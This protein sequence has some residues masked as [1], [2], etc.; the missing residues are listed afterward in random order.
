MTPD[1]WH[2]VSRIF[3]ATL[4]LAAPEREGYLRAACA[5]DEALRREVASLLAQ[6][7]ADGFLAVPPE[8]PRLTGHRLGPYTL[9]DL[10]GSGGMGEVYRARDEALGR[11][12]A[13]KILP[14]RFA[15][16]PERLAR[17]EREARLLAAL[18]HPNIAAIHGVERTGALRGL[19]LELVDGETLAQRL[20]RGPLPIAEA[21]AV[22][23]AIAD[24]L[25]AA[26]ER[27]I[28]HRDLKPANI[29]V[30][31]D[32]AVKILDFGLAKA[33]ARADG[34]ES[35]AP[36]S[37][38]TADGRLLGTPA[39]MSPEQARGKPVDRRT[40]VWAFGCVLYE[41]LTARAAFDGDTAQDTLAAVLAHQPDLARLPPA[42]PANV[43]RLLARCLA[44]DPRHRLRDMGDARLEL[45]DATTDAVVEQPRR[46]PSRRGRAA[47]W[48]LSAGALGLAAW[49]AAA[50]V[51]DR[52]SARAV[53]A[54]PLEQLTYDAGL[55]TTPAVS[56]DGL[57]I[58]YASDRASGRD[59][60][61]WV[62]Q[63][64]GTTPLRLTD[65]PEDE[66]A[67]DFSPDGKQIAFRS[68][69]GGG[70]IHLV[71]ALGGPARVVVPEGRRP[72]FSPDGS[73]LAYWTGQF[74][75]LANRSP[76]AVFVAPLD[77]GPPRRLL[78]TFAV[79]RDPVWSPDGRSLLVLG[80]PGGG[81]APGDGLDWWLVPVDGGP[82]AAT[83]AF[84]TAALR[85]AV[86]VRDEGSP[87]A[88]TPRGVLFAASGD[89]WAMPI[90]AGGRLSAP[91]ERLTVSVGDA[92]F[93]S[94]APDGRIIFAATHVR[95][96]I[97]RASLGAAA[98]TE[99]PVPLHSDERR[100]ALRASPSADGRVIAYE[101]S[102]PRYREIWARD[103]RTGHEQMVVRAD[104][105]FVTSPTLSPSGTRIA[106]ASGSA[107]AADGLVIDV[108]GGVPRTLCRRCAVSGFLSDDRRVLAAWDDGRVLGTIDAIDGTQ[109]AIVRAREGRLDRPHASPDDRWLAFRSLVAATGSLFVARLDPAVPQGPDAWQRVEQ[110]TLTGRPCG[111]SLDSRTLYLLLD[112][113]GF[114]CLWAQQ[115]AASGPAGAVAPVRHFHGGQ[116]DRGGPSTSLGNPV[117][118]DGFV[119]ER[120]EVSGNLWRLPTPSR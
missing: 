45:A 80:E 28:V 74:R 62:Q 102:Y 64:D 57:L 3:H 70:A 82:P 26:H 75:G 38:E 48:V 15:G 115:V 72:R 104:S 39:Y 120:T 65:D 44:K 94:R 96:I 4:A 106:Y 31:G 59:L 2:E 118:A 32:G 9:G 49:L 35:P 66:H 46:Q 24:G 93:P 109:R 90:S 12:V 40:D 58:A 53:P 51:A 79:A 68:E 101:K 29:T 61:I 60:D 73:R 105:P 13:I 14:A 36:A 95:R 81:T 103:L 92:T 43:R 87:A 89:L 52:A 85:D 100:F 47:P 19:I 6:P 5:G 37:N 112:T 83:G 42:T 86:T 119:Y 11:D 110:P 56:A 91:A 117:T 113:D 84:R 10:L 21:V 78:P 8:A 107:D 27:G 88:W 63:S 116:M 108:T 50:R 20:R 54:G 33:L 34:A 76:S 99:P 30:T 22:A 25:E 111:W 23:A 114:R 55:T 67:P 17:F 77:G 41:M 71:P 16:D 69:R 18:N 7:S 1:R 97:E 98:D